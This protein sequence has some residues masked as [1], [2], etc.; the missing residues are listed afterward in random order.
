VNT[1]IVAERIEELGAC[2]GVRLAVAASASDGL[3]IHA[4]G[5]DRAHAAAAAALFAASFARAGAVSALTRRG[6]AHVTRVRARGAQILT[7]AAGSLVLIAVAR[8]DAN[9]GR[10]RL[11][12]RRAVEALA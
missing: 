7:A 5:E 11:E 1:G 8:R 9:A 10:V 12:L 3:V 4:S 6:D 2:P